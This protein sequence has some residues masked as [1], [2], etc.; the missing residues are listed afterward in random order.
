M[1]NRVSM[2]LWPPWIVSMVVPW[3]LLALQVV[4][5]SVATVEMPP[6]MVSCHR[7]SLSSE[8]FRAGLVWYRLPRA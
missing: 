5:S 3:S 6:R 4:Y 2:P 8:N 7:A 1:M